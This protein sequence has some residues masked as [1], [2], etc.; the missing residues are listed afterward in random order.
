MITNI[1][2]GRTNTNSTITKAYTFFTIKQL[3]DKHVAQFMHCYQENKL[4]KEFNNF[5]P[6]STKKNVNSKIY[7]NNFD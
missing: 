3:L 4:P 1:S 5:F 2:Q 7:S 6:L